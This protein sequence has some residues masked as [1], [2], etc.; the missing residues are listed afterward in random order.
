M[1]KRNKKKGKKIQ[2]QEPNNNQIQ[3]NNNNILS[4]IIS[5]IP[6]PNFKAFSINFNIKDYFQPSSFINGISASKGYQSFLDG[7]NRN[8]IGTDKYSDYNTEFIKPYF[9]QD[10]IDSLTIKEGKYD[11]IGI[12]NGECLVYNKKDKKV[13]SH[14]CE[15]TKKKMN[16]L[17]AAAKI[18]EMDR[19]RLTS[20]KRQQPTFDTGDAPSTAVVNDL[21]LTNGSEEPTTEDDSEQLMIDNGSKES[22]TEDDSKI[23]MIGTRSEE[24]PT[25]DGSN[26]QMIEAGPDANNDNLSLE[27]GSKVSDVPE[28]L[29]IE[30]SRP[31]SPIPMLSSSNGFTNI[32]IGEN[33]ENTPPPSSSS[34]PPPSSQTDTDTV[35][36][37]K[38]YT[39]GNIKTN[40]IKDGILNLGKNPI[41]RQNCKANQF[42]TS[43]MCKKDVSGN[44]L[45]EVNNIH[46][47]IYSPDKNRKCIEYANDRFIQQTEFCKEKEIPDEYKDSPEYENKY[48][49]AKKEVE[50]TKA[51]ATTKTATATTKTATAAPKTATAQA[52][53]AAPLAITNEAAE[54]TN[55]A[56][57]AI[58]NTAE[59]TNTA[60]TNTAESTNTAKTNTAESTN[61]AITNGPTKAAAAPAL[62]ETTQDNEKQE[63]IEQA[64]NIIKSINPT[65]ENKQSDETI[66]QSFIRYK[67]YLSA[68]NDKITNSVL[69]SLKNDES[70]KII[71]N[72]IEGL[73]T[74]IKKDFD[75]LI[76]GPIQDD[77]DRNIREEIINILINLN[78]ILITGLKLKSLELKKIIFPIIGNINTKIT[79]YE[80]NAIKN[81]INVTKP[82]K[83]DF[84]NIKDYFST[85]KNNIDESAIK[86][87]KNDES[88]N[89]ITEHIKDLITNIKKD[90]DTL[91]NGP[92]QDNVDRNI[93][94]ETKQILIGLNN[95]LTNDMKSKK[96]IGIDP[97]IGNINKKIEEYDK[98]KAQAQTDSE[99]DRESRTENEGQTTTENQG[100]T[101]TENKGRTTTTENE[102][103]KVN[104]LDNLPY[105]FSGNIFNQGGGKKV[106]KTKKSK[107]SK[108][109]HQKKHGRKT[110]KNRS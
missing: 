8:I 61:T 33:G 10:I 36:V 16:E 35:D 90:F 2:P 18:Q 65:L 25:G 54:S 23:L 11:I 48:N 28:K 110:R 47:L 66:Q 22:T 80:A 85:I 27:N 31:S 94:E 95:K 58:T 67:N 57:L 45:K 49:N 38:K 43:D 12:F 6:N 102:G 64:N 53:Q 34:L 37:M 24:T 1:L 26:I 14:N 68:I 41:D 50:S 108:K 17:E 5:R 13:E 44:Y 82:K 76:N 39:I 52:A 99:P 60:K 63:E 3:N 77:V 32:P 84:N 89:I 74:N 83:I 20:N 92:I 73:I 15:L 91:I 55:T 62:G 4:N 106:N 96:K 86:Q 107:K 98:A 30:H 51:A 88:K 21:L 9:P 104:P 105:N 75:T 101:T 79:N 19:R 69:D 100:Q 72:H 97:F 70:K 81:K 78:N 7:F 42:I 109:N 46:R 103:Q 56:P 59:S 29:M 71:T 93:R 87:L 40:I